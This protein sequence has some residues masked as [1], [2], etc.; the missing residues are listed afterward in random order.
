LRA[1]GTSLAFVSAGGRVLDR[2]RVACKPI[3]AGSA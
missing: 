3:T 2:H 1:G